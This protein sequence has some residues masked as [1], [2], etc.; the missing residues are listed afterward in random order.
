MIYELI[1]GFLVNINIT[2]KK[3]GIKLIYRN[4]KLI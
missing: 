1:F 4:R 2:I 3:K